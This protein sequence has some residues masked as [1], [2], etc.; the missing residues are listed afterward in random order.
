MAIHGGDGRRGEVE[1]IGQKDDLALMDY[2][3]PG[4]PAGESL[5]VLG[6]LRGEHDD[7][8][9]TNVRVRRRNT[10]GRQ[11]GKPVEVA[12]APLKDGLV[13]G[14]KLQ[15]VRDLAIGNRAFGDDG[16]FRQ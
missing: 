5:V 1:V 14:R 4:H 2:V 12:A 13:A 7:L 16:V 11:M 8:V 15:L 10:A 6:G 9:G 3:L